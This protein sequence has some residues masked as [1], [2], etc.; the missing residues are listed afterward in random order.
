MTQDEL[1]KSQKPTDF[2][3]RQAEDGLQE[4]QKPVSFFKQQAV[5]ALLA[6]IS[7]IDEAS[8]SE[9]KVYDEFTERQ[10]SFISR[11]AIG[12]LASYIATLAFFYR[13]VI[14]SPQ[15]ITPTFDIGYVWMFIAGIVCLAVTAGLCRCVNYLIFKIRKQNQKIRA[16]NQRYNLP[17]KMAGDDDVSQSLISMMQ[18]SQ[19]E[20]DPHKK[21]RVRLCKWAAWSLFIIALVITALMLFAMGRYTWCKLSNPT[22]TCQPSTQSVINSDTETT[23]QT[24]E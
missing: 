3:N 17:K 4:S 9:N 20:D 14:T 12:I 10:Y 7:I 13:G 23:K 11:L 24:N 19:D 22:S 1:R 2:F 8:R 5:D 6:D 21:L 18:V 16:D 15:E